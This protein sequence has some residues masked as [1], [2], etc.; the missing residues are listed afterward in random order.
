VFYF[1]LGYT[2]WIGVILFFWFQALLGLVLLRAAKSSGNS[3]GIL[4]WAW[5]LTSSMFGNGFETPFGAIPYYLAVGM[6]AADFDAKAVS[7]E[8][9]IRAPALVSF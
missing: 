9:F 7:K 2:G 6:A 5:M 3:F 8:V 1:A 4:L